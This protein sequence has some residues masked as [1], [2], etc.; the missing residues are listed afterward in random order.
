[1]RHP[2]RDDAASGLS[3]PDHPYRDTTWF[4][5]WVNRREDV[6]LTNT[7]YDPYR[8]WQLAPVAEPGLNID[9][10]GRR[11]TPQPAASSAH[12]RLVFL[13]GASLMWGYTPPHS[14]PLPSLGAPTP[15]PPG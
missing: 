9:A 1:M 8:G 13:L 12:P 6:F 3:R 11:G 14:A 4:R 7:R 10:E 15:A 5:S 2:F